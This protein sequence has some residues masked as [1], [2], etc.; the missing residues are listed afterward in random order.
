[1]SATTPH[2][3]A[4]D[5]HWK[6]ERWWLVLK[7]IAA[8]NIA[9]WCFTAASVD[10]STALVRIHL[11][12]SGIYVAACAFRSVRPRVDLERTALVDDWTSSMV[13]GRSAA[14]I[15]EVSF[16]TQIALFV[17]QASMASGVEAFQGLFAVFIVATLALA[18]VFCWWSV[19]T[20]SH[21]GHAIEESL[22]GVTF[23]AVTASLLV[24]IPSLTGA[25][26]WAA[27]IA[28]PGCVAYV[29]FMFTVDVPMY[30]RRWRAGSG[31]QLG[32]IEGFKDAR[33]RREVTRSWTVWKP[34]V[35]WMTGYFSC[36]VWTSIGLVHLAGT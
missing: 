23:A 30:V 26:W 5:E 14:T 35:A 33:D 3:T 25:L 11:A 28:S 24:M 36:A 29:V 10:S 20:L 31:A 9:A 21:L 13:L 12:L 22:W 8:F 4:S 1:M 16:A 19:V 2:D 15:A 27:V 32:I 6:T 7:G 17:H 34:E 18:Q